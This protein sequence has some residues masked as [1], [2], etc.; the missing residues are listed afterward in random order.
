MVIYFKRIAEKKSQNLHTI[1]E[2][3]ETGSCITYQKQVS[4]CTKRKNRLEPVS[5]V[6]KWLHSEYLYG[7]RG[8]VIRRNPNYRK[9][10]IKFLPEKR[11]CLSFYT[12]QQAL[13]TGSCITSSD[14]SDK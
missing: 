4:S 9:G 10:T 5:S 6:P 14:S 12:I 2:Y 8:W 11:L 1:I 13:D 3:T 7:L